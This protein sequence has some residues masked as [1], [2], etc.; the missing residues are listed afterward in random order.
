MK[1]ISL[2]IW[3]SIFF[4]TIFS[5]CNN[6]PV[7]P[8]MVDVS[9]QVGYD[10]G[11]LHDVKVEI[12]GRIT[13]TDGEGKFSIPDVTIPYDL[14]VMTSNGLDVM[15][16]KG[17]TTGKPYV[18]F[19]P[20]YIQTTSKQ[21]AK[22][23]ATLDSM[24]FGNQRVFS[25][26]VPEEGQP[27]ALSYYFGGTGQTN[28]RTDIYWFGGP[29]IKGKIILMVYTVLADRIQKFDKYYE[30]NALVINDNTTDTVVFSNTS[31]HVTNGSVHG[32][33]DNYHGIP[34]SVN[35]RLKFKNALTQYLIDRTYGT[36]VFTFVVPQNIP[37]QFDIEVE[38]VEDELYGKK[39]IQPNSV[40]NII[41]LYKPVDLVSPDNYDSASIYL[42]PFSWNTEIPGPGLYELEID[43]YTGL[44]RKIRVIGEQS[45]MTVPNLSDIGYNHLGGGV[46][47]KWS[48][49]RFFGLSRINEFVNG[50]YR[51]SNAFQGESTSDYRYI[52]IY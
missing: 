11:Y 47:Y 1:S 9:G 26:F 23:I 27:Q 4:L 12:D 37:E 10:F 8:G 31:A 19:E 17:L 51:N 44:F 16:V 50:N 25:I 34:S 22:I 32:T 14:K 33:I 40:N 3:V 41:K 24:P 48:V 6:D 18:N 46:T 36:F 5:S 38:A 30:K 7:A 42:T 45:K 20:G 2:V 15:V 29:V 21:G 43:N 39:F 35:M 13:T 28:V 52:R 49:K